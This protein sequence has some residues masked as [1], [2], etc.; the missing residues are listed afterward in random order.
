M[1]QPMA[2]QKPPKPTA[3]DWPLL[4]GS[5]F[6]S[7]R[8]LP[9]PVGGLSVLSAAD[10]LRSY[11]DLELVLKRAVEVARDR[12]GLERTAIF[13][14]DDSGT[15][16]CGTWGTGL[17]G[18]TTDEHHIFFEEGF[19][20]RQAKAQALAGDSP[21]LT[22]DEVPLI[23]QIEGEARVAGYGWNAITPIVGASNVL[24][25]FCNDAARSGTRLD[26]S[27]QVQLAILSRLLGGIID[28]LRRGPGVLPWQ[29]VLARLPRV[30]EHDSQSIV[31]TAV[32]A[33]HGN[34]S[35]PA[36]ALAKRLG[37]SPSRL[38]A[39][40]REQ[41]GVSIV[42]YRNR[43]RIERFFT[44]VAPGG[45]NLLQAALD[46]G[47]GSYAQFHRVFRDLLGTTPKEYLTGQK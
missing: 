27:K 30:G 37:L 43:L 15:K 17:S 41:M 21:W 33:L 31:I 46:A 40:F 28:D 34:P 42:E 11:R 10:E 36:G 6:P 7:P 24:G 44:L 14:Y 13:L 1:S 29:S 25:L 16:L 23:V 45:G 3:V 20:H 2:A 5:H 9:S 47:F 35:L 39:L 26:E 19:H 22:F 38:T 4:T 32:H 8:T 18:E 12:I